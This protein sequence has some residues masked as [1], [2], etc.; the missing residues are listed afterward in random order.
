MGHWLCIGTNSGVSPDAPHRLKS[1]Q[2]STIKLPKTAVSLFF[3]I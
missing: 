3:T 1:R 2:P